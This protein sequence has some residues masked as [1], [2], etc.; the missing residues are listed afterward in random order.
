MRRSNSARLVVAVAT[1]GCEEVWKPPKRKVIKLFSYLISLSSALE[2]G[3]GNEGG[4]TEEVGNGIDFKFTASVLKRTGT[5]YQTTTTTKAME[6]VLN[7][8]YFD[9]YQE[10]YFLCNIIIY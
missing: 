1:V 8:S 4:G 10:Q 9:F 2:A 3:M 5:R 7:L 6:E